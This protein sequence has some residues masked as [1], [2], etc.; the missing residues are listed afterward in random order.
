MNLGC[1][2]LYL[3]PL[4]KPL[5]SRT[6]LN[7]AF[8][9]FEIRINI[10]Q[11]VKGDSRIRNKVIHLSDKMEGVYDVGTFRSGLIFLRKK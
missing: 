8:T 6:A 7:D 3:S 1:K 5:K 9:L 10:E 11:N 4:R 2:Y